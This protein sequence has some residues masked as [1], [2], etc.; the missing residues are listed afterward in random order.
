MTRESVCDR[1]RFLDSFIHLMRDVNL[2]VFVKVSVNADK[3]TDRN[4]D[5]VVVFGV[6]AIVVFDDRLAGEEHIVFARQDNTAAKLAGFILGNDTA[7]DICLSV[8]GVDAAAEF[9]SRVFSDRTAGDCQSTVVVQNT[10]AAFGMVVTDRAA[11]QHYFTAV[12][13]D[14]AGVVCC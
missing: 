6:F 9:I 13:H 10:A 11:F 7:M 4:E 5:I 14:A 12:D 3:T 2:R 1:R 8:Y